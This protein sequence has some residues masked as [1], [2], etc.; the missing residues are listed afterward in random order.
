MSNNNEERR[1]SIGWKLNSKNRLKLE[2]KLVLRNV[3]ES[4]FATEET[5]TSLFLRRLGRP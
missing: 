2:R 4:C 1:D 5:R 3:T